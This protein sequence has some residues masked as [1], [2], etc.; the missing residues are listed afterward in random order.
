MAKIISVEPLPSQGCE[1]WIAIGYDDGSSENRQLR[2][3]QLVPRV[4]GDEAGPPA[5]PT[6]P[7]SKPTQRV[8]FTVVLGGKRA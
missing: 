6:D 1:V 5:A 4:D 2:P 7:H 3:F 8:Q